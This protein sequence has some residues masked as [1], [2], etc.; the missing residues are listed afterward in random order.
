MIIALS[1][2]I[3]INI[4]CIYL[5]W[6]TTRKISILENYASTFLSD[7]TDLKD[8]ISKANTVIKQADTL[9]AFESDDEVGTAFQIIKDCLNRLDSDTIIEKEYG[10]E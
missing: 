10:K 1:I 4:V 3:I 7:L 5:V 2:S 8:R 6:N 9:G